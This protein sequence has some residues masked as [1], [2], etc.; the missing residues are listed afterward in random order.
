MNELI[1]TNNE[2]AIN[3]K[4]KI[5]NLENTIKELQKQEKQLREQLLKEM[6]DKGIV[7][8]DSDELLITKKESTYRE[9]FNT[10]KFKAENED[11]YNDYVSFSKVKP[12][13]LIKV[14]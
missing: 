11:L 9:T 10:K 4:Q 1:T 14:K 8:F 5:I 3:A 12:S 13:L 2:L 6:E 7:K